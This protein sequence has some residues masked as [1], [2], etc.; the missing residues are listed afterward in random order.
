[1]EITVNVGD[2]QS[3]RTAT[4]KIPQEDAKSVFGKRL[5]DTIRGELI[6]KPGYEMLITGG[7][8][9]AGFPMRRDVQ[10]SARRKLLLTKSLGNRGTERGVRVR[11]TV[12]GNTVSEITSQ[13]NVKVTKHGKDP[14]VE[15]KP[16]EKKEE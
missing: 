14:L 4:F 13:L 9:S 1:M 5:G 2:P 7:S 3:K 16:A 12:S 15:E 11:K 10:G 6:G 8:D